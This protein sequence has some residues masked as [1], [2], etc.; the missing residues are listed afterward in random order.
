VRESSPDAVNREEE[1]GEN[2][3]QRTGKNAREKELADL[4]QVKKR[5]KKNV[6]VLTRWRIDRESGTEKRHGN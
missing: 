2:N 6:S 1:K 5:G 4:A 3:D